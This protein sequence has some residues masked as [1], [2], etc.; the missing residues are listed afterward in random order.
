MPKDTERVQY[1]DIARTDWSRLQSGE[2]KPDREPGSLAAHNSWLARIVAAREAENERR[3]SLKKPQPPEQEDGQPQR[4]NGTNGAG[5]ST[6]D[7]GAFS[8]SLSSTTSSSVPA[9]N[10]L[11]LASLASV[12]SVSSVA[13]KPQDSARHHHHGNCGGHEKADLEAPMPGDSLPS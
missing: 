5:P 13:P 2:Q 6:S 10:G 11:S 1:T 7:G 3:L 4:A 9:R 12:A 8:A